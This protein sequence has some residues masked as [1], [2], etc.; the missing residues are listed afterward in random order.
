MLKYNAELVS[1]LKRDLAFIFGVD[2]VALAG[3]AVRDLLLNRPIKDYDFVIVVNEEKKNFKESLDKLFA[4][5]GKLLGVYI[6]YAGGDG[7]GEEDKQSVYKFEY[8]GE[9]VNLLCYNQ[10]EHISAVIAKNFDIGLCMCYYNDKLGFMVHA[11]FIENFKTKQLT[12]YRTHFGGANAVN[13]T[14]HLKR[15]NKK[16]PEFTRTVLVSPKSSGWYAQPDLA[17]ID[18]H[19]G[20]YV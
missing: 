14:N 5:F 9:E 7:Y 1:M 2:N 4:D 12:G 13:G 8:L 15:V 11:E 19:W 16:Y 18:P 6:Y 20:W 10:P 3:G 17:R